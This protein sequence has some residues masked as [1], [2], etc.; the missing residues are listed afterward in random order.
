MSKVPDPM[1]LRKVG[2]ALRMVL[3]LIGC[4]CKAYFLSFLSGRRI[5]FPAAS[6]FLTHILIWCLYLHYQLTE[7]QFGV[8]TDPRPAQ[9]RNPNASSSLC[10]D[11]RVTVHIYEATFLWRCYRLTG[12]KKHTAERNGKYNNNQ[13]VV[14]WWRKLF[15]QDKFRQSVV[16]YTV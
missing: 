7:H 6:F 1:H 10:C 11:E 3:K 12:M 2:G 5:L 4:Q 13:W 9:C 15:N 8:S 14:A 16:S